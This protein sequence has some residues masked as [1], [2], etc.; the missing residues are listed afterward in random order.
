MRQSYRLLAFGFALAVAT[1]AGAQSANN[2]SLVTSMIDMLTDASRWHVALHGGS[3]SF[4]NFLLQQTPAGAVALRANR[5]FAV[6]GGGGFDVDDNSQIK[7]DYTYTGSQTQYRDWTGTGSDLLNIRDLGR[8][9]TNAVSLEADHYFVGSRSLVSPYAGF[10]VAGIWSHLSPDAVLAN[11]AGGTPVVAPLLT[12][13]GGSQKFGF[14]ATANLGAQVR[15]TDEFFARAEWATMNTPNP[16]NGNRSFQAPLAVTYD[17]PS[18]VSKNEWR[19][20]AVYYLGKQ[21][22]SQQRPTVATSP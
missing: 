19:L 17:Q 11:L 5:S 13:P 1:P 10:G 6:G 18:R 15:I 22:P 3:G 20:A 2:D 8:L 7:L 12:T 14:G 21:A 9:T 4:G 16:F